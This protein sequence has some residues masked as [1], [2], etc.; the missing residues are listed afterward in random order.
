MM[1]VETAGCEPPAVGVTVRDVGLPAGGSHGDR[2]VLHA[3]G[4]EC[5]S[6][7]VMTSG[8]QRD[9]NLQREIIL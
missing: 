5:V 2:G 1:R 7:D 9:V 3:R 8:A 4:D 6:D